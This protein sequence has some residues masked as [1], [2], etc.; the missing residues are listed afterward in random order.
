MATQT[1]SL[2]ALLQARS[3]SLLPA[4]QSKVWL[5]AG[6]GSVA[7]KTHERMMRWEFMDLG[8]L[9]PKHPLDKIPAEPDT[10]RLVVLPGF[11]ISQAR[12][13]PIS[14]IITWTHCY[15]RY[16]AAMAAAYPT[17]M[18]GFMAHLVTVLKAYTEVEDPA[19]RLYDEAFREKMAATGC[20]LWEGMDIQVYQEVCAGRLRRKVPAAQVGESSGNGVRGGMKRAW[21]ERRPGP[22]VCWQFNTGACRYGT[23]CRFAHSC[24]ICFGPHPKFRCAREAEKKRKPA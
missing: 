14:N 8:E 13:K 5:G 21:E 9:C 22:A 23:S 4:K 10:E 2:M 19:W 17:S 20:K 7:K 12:Q 18:P 11:E 16:T 15:A 3:E 1:A 6:L 24:G